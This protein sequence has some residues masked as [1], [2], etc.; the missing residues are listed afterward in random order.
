MH[1]SSLLSLLTKTSPIIFQALP[2]STAYYSFSCLAHKWNF[3]LENKSIFY[4]RLFF[5]PGIEGGVRFK[6]KS[7][8]HFSHWRGSQFNSTLCLFLTCRWNRT[9]N[10]AINWVWTLTIS[11]FCITF[12]CKVQVSVWDAISHIMKNGQIPSLPDLNLIGQNWPNIL[13]KRQIC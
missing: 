1:K 4:W 12:V 6:S 7:S 11:S 3:N 2:V 10:S 8:F 5:L 13:K 9:Q